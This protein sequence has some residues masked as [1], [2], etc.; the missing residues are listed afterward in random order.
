MALATGDQDH[1]GGAW[2]AL[3]LVATCFQTPMIVND[4]TYDARA[5]F[6][7]SLRVYTGMGAEA[8][9]ARTLREWAR[10]E[11]AQGAREL[12]GEMR[13]GARKI[14]S[15]LGMSFELERTAHDTE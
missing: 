11:Q 13:A 12:G 14:F 7:E 6:A 15:R 5:C 4:Q 9:R 2:R 8:E 10:Y 3:G 1:I